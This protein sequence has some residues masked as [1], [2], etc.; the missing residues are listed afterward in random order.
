MPRLRVI[1]LAL[2]L[3]IGQVALALDPDKPF[4]QYVLDRW[5]VEDGFPQVSALQIVQDRTGYIWATTQSGLTRFDGVRFTSFNVQNT[6]ELL[7]DHLEVL[8]VDHRGWLWIGS[9]RGITVREGHRFRI[10]AEAADGMGAVRDIADGAG[11]TVW[12]AA[13]N[14]IFRHHDGRLERVL[15]APGR[16]LFGDSDRLWVGGDELLIEIRSGHERRIEVPGLKVRQIARW[17]GALWLG[18]TAGLHRLIDDRIDQPET[19]SAPLG[20]SPIDLLYVDRHDSLW[21]GSY[22]LLARLFA[23]GRRELVDR[24]V[25]GFHPWIIAAAEDHEGNLWLG[26]QTHSLIRLWDGWTRRYSTGHGLAD[27]FVWSVAVDAADAMWIGT[28]SGLSR[29]IDGEIETVVPGAE[30]PNAAVYTLLVD[31]QC[32]WLGTRG[33]VARWCDGRLERPPQLR[34]LDSLQI[35][36]IARDDA[37]E[38]WFATSDGLYRHPP[39][40]SLVRVPGFAGNSEN[41]VRTL[42]PHPDGWLVGTEAGLFHLVDGE[43]RRL[44][45]DTGVGEAFVTAVNRLPDGRVAVGTLGRG[46]FLGTIEDQWVQ[47]DQRWGVPDGGI[48]YLHADADGY[49]WIGAEVGAFRVELDSLPDGATEPVRLLAVQNLASS[50]QLVGSQPARCCNG[51]GG[52]K[53]LQYQ[54][55]YWFPTLDGVLRIEPEKIVRTAEQPRVVVEAVQVRDE[56]LPMRGEPIVLSPEQRDFAVRFTALTYQDPRHVMFRYRLVGYDDDWV[57]A[58]QRRAA[59]YTNLAPGSYR[60]EVVATS[61]AGRWSAMPAALPLTIQPRLTETVAF[62]A[63]AVALGLGLLLALYGIRMA[64]ARRVRSRLEQLVNERTRA[65]DEVNQLLLEANQKLERASE[66]DALTGLRNRRFLLSR[67]Q[68][69]SPQARGPFQP[70][71]MPMLVVLADI[72]RFK[73][74]NDVHG[75]GAGDEMLRQFG[76]LLARHIREGDAAVRWGGEEFLLLLGDTTAARAGRVLERIRAAVSMHR[77]ELPDSTLVRLSCSF[78]AA[79]LQLDDGLTAAGRQRRW[80]LALELADRGLYAVKR[81]GRDGWALLETIKETDPGG[82]ASATIDGWIASAAVK[83]R[84]SRGGIASHVDPASRRLDAVDPP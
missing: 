21:I 49:L 34:A 31:G 45:G 61:S 52:A 66:T 32:I 74:I 62:R 25:I 6:P 37:G 71:R 41:R 10:V 18:T 9:A 60:F 72:D 11:G 38:Y 8:H 36:A 3:L 29:M 75:H 77:F 68:Q 35:N 16:T 81:G 23:D 65:L 42:V 73:A 80:A 48:F 47:L 27:P 67:L 19:L 20:D 76:E 24:E 5:S 30:L 57:W 14:G 51:A 33:G 43:R 4:T 12:I 78:G 13:D 84:A 64:T 17:Q 39:G 83:V 56:V 15:D 26:S 54:G 44:G 70:E 58:G 79:I 53:G 1:L 46:L 55:S 59:Y 50:N 82:S 7:T 40:G 69:A 63:G 28:N 22:A 2:G